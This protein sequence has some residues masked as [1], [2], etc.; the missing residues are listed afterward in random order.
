MSHG[1]ERAPQDIE[2]Q[3]FCQIQAVC[4]KSRQTVRMQ[5]GA[6]FL[7]GTVGAG[8]TTTAEAIGYALQE[9]EVPY[10]IIDL[11]WFRN[12]WP[13]P[14]DDPFNLALELRNL[15]AV[16]A[17]FR[18]AEATVL[19]L[20]GVIEEPAE[21]ASY[22]R[23]LGLPLTVCR[24]KVS[25]PRLHSR[26]IARHQPGAERDWH[27]ARIDELDAILDR[28]QVGRRDSARRR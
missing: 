27:L 6:L 18:H 1:V 17:N 3:P 24:L 10:A 23:A 13:A 4:R 16:A 9:H 7:N 12:A 5:P 20:A 11:D 14:A 19:V 25:A 26:I 15:A 28:A 22:E 21:R 2:A 8:K